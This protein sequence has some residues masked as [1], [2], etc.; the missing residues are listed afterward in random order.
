MLS[1][2]KLALITYI[3][4]SLESIFQ[5]DHANTISLTAKN[6][7]STH[8]KRTSLHHTPTKYEW[9]SAQAL[10]VTLNVPPHYH[11]GSL[12]S[13]DKVAS[14]KLQYFL[15]PQWNI[16]LTPGA[17]LQIDIKDQM[18]KRA[19][20]LI[21]IQSLRHRLQLL[22]YMHVVP[23]LPSLFI[24]TSIRVLAHWNWLILAPYIHHSGISNLLVFPL[25]ISLVVSSLPLSLP[26]IF[27]PGHRPLNFLSLFMSFLQVLACNMNHWHQLH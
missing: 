17:M 24:I 12:L 18:W 2:Y 1:H 23:S 6:S 25:L 5:W 11:R 20:Q 22:A 8:I 10:T 26:K 14:P 9:Y 27:L 21:N 4:G 7:N 13:K 16:A 3:N 19:V 15:D